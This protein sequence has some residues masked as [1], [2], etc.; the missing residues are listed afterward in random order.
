VHRLR[1]TPY[2]IDYIDPWVHAPL[3]HDR[4]FNKHWLSRQ[5]GRVLE[6]F[7]IREAAAEDASG[8]GCDAI[9]WGG[10]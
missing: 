2:G 3:Q 9:R 10:R 8:Y 5:L 7:A 6:P 4:L 1:G